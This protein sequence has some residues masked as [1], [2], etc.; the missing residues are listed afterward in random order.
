[1]QV[2]FNDLKRFYV[3]MADAMRETLE[4]VASSGWYIM[5]SEHKAFEYEFAAYCGL[6]HAVAVANGTDA[7]ELALRCVDCGPGDEVITA[8]NA[9]GYTSTAVL[10]VGATPVY[11]DIDPDMLTLSPDSVAAALGDRTKA[12]VVTHLFGQLGDVDAIRRTIGD[13]PVAVIE[14]CAQAH[15][16][17]AEGRRAGAW[18]DLG[19]FSFYP[20]KNLGGMGDG[21]AVVCGNDDFAARLRT[22]RQYGWHDRYKSV[23]PGGRNSRM[24]EIQAAVLRMKL[25][26]LDRW[27]EKRRAIVTRYRTAAEGTP[28]R[29]VHV[30]GLSYVG[31]LCVALHEERDTLR[32]CFANRGIATAIH[33]PYLDPYQP[34][35]KNRQWRAVDLSVSQHAVTRIVSL[36]CFPELTDREIAHVCDVI[37]ACA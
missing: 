7:L 12:V 27:N 26:Y 22:L 17:M 1:M 21:G 30:P 28:L 6:P 11:A 37:R 13:R 3:A 15:G 4:R 29:I 32:E 18:G 19:T 20:T 33:Y 9:G 36:P 24:D 16:A 14:D 8:A 5:G 2:P 23:T 10:L 35:M 31:H 25:P 34:A